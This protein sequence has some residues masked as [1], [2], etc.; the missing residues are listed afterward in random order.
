MP[1]HPKI[2]QGIELESAKRLP[3]S[4][5]EGSAAIGSVFI[6]PGFAPQMIKKAEYD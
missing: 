1:H 6:Q 4:H 2:L 5:E 3:Q